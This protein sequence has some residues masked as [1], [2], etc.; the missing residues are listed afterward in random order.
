MRYE[1]EF[2]EIATSI[3]RNSP[4]SERMYQ[5]SQKKEMDYSGE[6]LFPPFDELPRVDGRPV[7][8]LWGFFDQDGKKDELGSMS[9]LMFY[10]LFS[11]QSN[12]CT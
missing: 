2:Y 4:N 12:Y 1:I 5:G 11:A 9:I 8:C 3:H 6:F 10:L 7:G